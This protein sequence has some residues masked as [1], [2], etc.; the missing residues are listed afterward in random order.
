MNQQS[1]EILYTA[2]F[3]SQHNLSQ[4]IKASLVRRLTGIKGSVFSL[5]ISE[6]ITEEFVVANSTV[7]GNLVLSNK[8]ITLLNQQLAVNRIL[9]LQ[10]TNPQFLPPTSRMVYGYRYNYYF[11][12]DGKIIR[13]GTIAVLVS[14]VLSM[15]WQL[16]FN[17]IDS[18]AVRLL[19]LFAKDH[20]VKAFTD[21]SMTS[22]E[23]VELMTNNQPPKPP[24]TEQDYLAIQDAKFVILNSNTK[25]TSSD[26][27]H[28]VSDITPQIDQSIKYNRALDWY[29][30]VKNIPNQNL[31]STTLEF[32]QRHHLKLV[33][34]LDFINLLYKQI[35]DL[36]SS[37]DRPDDYLNQLKTLP[38]A[39]S[40]R[41]TLFG[42]IL[43]WHGGYPVNNLNPQYNAI[44]QLVEREFLSMT[45]PEGSPEKEFC[46]IDETI[47]N[48]LRDLENELNKQFGART[49][50]LLEEQKIIN[51]LNSSPDDE[52]QKEFEYVNQDDPEDENVEV[53]PAFFQ[54]PEGIHAYINDIVYA[55]FGNITPVMGVTG[56]A[57]DYCKVLSTMRGETGQMIGIFGKWGRGKTFFLKQL[58]LQMARSKSPTFIQVDYHA[59]KYQETPA[60]WAYLYEQFVEGYLGKKKWWRIR[61]HWRLVRL[62][63]KR[64]GLY[65]IL[66]YLGTLSVAIASLFIPLESFAIKAGAVS[67]IVA[68]TTTYLLKL[69]KDFS[70]K[71][72]NLIKKYHLRNSFKS[73]LGIQADIQDELIKLLKVWIPQKECGQT[74]IILVVEDIDRCSEEKIIQN[75]DALRVLLEDQEVAKRVLIITAIDERILKNAILIKYKGL[76]NTKREFS[77]NSTTQQTSEHHE[78]ISEYLDKLFISAIKLGELN[79]LQVKEYMLQLIKNEM[80][81]NGS[82]AD[83]AG[84]T[85]T[86]AVT[87]TEAAT[88]NKLNLLAPDISNQ[89]ASGSVPVG[90]TAKSTGGLQEQSS[91]IKLTQVELS[92]LETIFTNWIHPTPRKMRI[93]YYRY[94]LSKNQLI[95]K[96]GA[97]QRPN[98][99]QYPIGIT[100]IMEL[101]YFYSHAPNHGLI[102]RDYR[103]SWE[104][105]NEMIPI[106]HSSE[107]RTV[108]RMDLLYLLEV[109]ELTIAY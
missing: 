72:I 91:V 63:I 78:L 4:G 57:A 33:N 15:T 12:E 18:D 107:Q 47:Q 86:T 103:Q 106:P 2:Y 14:D 96:Y 21:G 98:I 39:Q 49:E 58:S 71:A 79:N 88:M 32:M 105:T 70:T 108:P 68:L 36:K 66:I 7:D 90:S 25:A 65:T 74:R 99:W 104:N 80:Q 10:I 37:L 97:L 29:T 83:Q 95:G 54:E 3:L 82:T 11:S 13:E 24:Y 35:D 75:I 20:L 73:S 81:D 101:I 87:S 50:E 34:P 84:A 17:N 77:E 51:L 41:Y 60:S 64:D 100:A 44:L 22:S 45:A 62:N 56:L 30:D 26:L 59:W 16:N 92:C 27:T 102:I 40:L 6:L 31:V 5:L 23:Q 53:P 28:A 67:A 42:M 38:V 89:S 76:L 9:I 61:Y 19:L 43:K 85:S 52:Q 55:E 109:L 94:L 93:F 48:R 69:K 46:R 8:G 1:L